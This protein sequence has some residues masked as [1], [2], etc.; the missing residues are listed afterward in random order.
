MGASWGAVKRTV[1]A[2]S[3]LERQAR[4]MA[5]HVA[6][7]RGLGAPLVRVPLAPDEE[8]RLRAVAAALRGAGL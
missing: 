2:A 1:A 4:E 8:G 7:L 5:R 6:T 3:H